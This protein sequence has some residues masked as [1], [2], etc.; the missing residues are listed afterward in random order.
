MKIDLTIG[1]SATI[2]LGNFNSMKPTISIT[3]HDID[4]NLDEAYNKMSEIAD[5]LFL[6]ET[7]NLGSE[8]VTAIKI[9]PERY[10]E[11]IS[12]YKDEAIKI[13]RSYGVEK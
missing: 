5:A 9:G 10:I 4:G 7:I 3:I 8:V 2:N 13:I 1:R 6:L 12:K 11:E